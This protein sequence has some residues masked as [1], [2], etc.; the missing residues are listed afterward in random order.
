MGVDQ[1]C[2]LRFTQETAMA[3]QQTEKYYLL[4]DR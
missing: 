1:C 2:E 3:Y 4:F